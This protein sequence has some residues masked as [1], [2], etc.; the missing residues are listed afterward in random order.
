MTKETLMHV[1]STALES[2]TF[3]N[4]GVLIEGH[5]IPAHAVGADVGI[6]KYEFSATPLVAV[7]LTIY[8]ESVSVDNASKGANIT[9]SHQ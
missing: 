6:V 9:I 8:A 4:E 7:T 5:R 1:M 2:V 3:D